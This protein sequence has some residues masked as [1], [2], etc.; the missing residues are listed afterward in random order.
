[1]FGHTNEVAI[2]FKDVDRFAKLKQKKENDV[3]KRMLRFKN[4]LRASRPQIFSFK[5]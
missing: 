1:M 2:T 4:A 3:E 5:F